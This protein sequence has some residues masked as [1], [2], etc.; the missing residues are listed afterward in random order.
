MLGLLIDKKLNLKGYTRRG[1]QNEGTVGIWKIVLSL[2]M[3]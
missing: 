2:R 3:L 1:Q